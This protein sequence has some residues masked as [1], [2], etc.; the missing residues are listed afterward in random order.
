[1][2][3]KPKLSGLLDDVA[4]KVIK[5]KPQGIR[6][7][8]GSPH[9]FDRFDL[10]KIGTG[11]GAQAYGHGLYFAE[12]EGVARGYRD[13][14]SRSNP[15][16]SGQYYDVDGQTVRFPWNGGPYDA[17]A[18]AAKMI[19]DVR[20][21][22]AQATLRA[23][24]AM[25]SGDT[26]QNWSDVVRSIEEIGSVSRSQGV[27]GRMYEVNIRANPEDF[28]DWDKPIGQQSEA[29]TNAVRDV[30]KQQGYLRENDNGPT[31]LAR[32]LKSWG[33]EKGGFVKDAPMSDVVAK[34]FGKP[35]QTSEVLR[36][37]GI[38]GIK[39]LDAGSRAAGDGSRNYVVFD[40]NLIDIIRKYGIVPGGLLG[41]GYAMAPSEAEAAPKVPM[42]RGQGMAMADTAMGALPQDTNRPEQSTL[43]RLYDA[44]TTNPVG[45]F[46]AFGSAIGDSVKDYAK[47]VYNEPSKGVADALE[48]GVT[49]LGGLVPQAFW[50]ATSPTEANAG[51]QAIL[52]ERIR[53]IAAQR[54]LLAE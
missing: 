42:P 43:G 15:Y 50:M 27:P 19:D 8:H 52:D 44:V 26:T 3:K 32:A 21:D 45:T 17:R 2:A 6:A 25:E 40:D 35:E 11:E 54:G 1:M 10:S 41:A 51:E 30:L 14:L 36:G 31:Q 13:A 22:K 39:Y 16:T 28:L 18:L 20:G 33:M 34:M 47:S 38:P 5:P 9:D 23:K 24:A 7:Y 29:V 53:R 46:K 4:E 49:S 48:L 12:N 37:A